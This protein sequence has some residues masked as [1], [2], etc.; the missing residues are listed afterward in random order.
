M[1]VQKTPIR[2]VHLFDEVRPLKEVLVWGEP[3][4]ETLLGQL[5]PQSRSLFHTY[6]EVPQAR[7]EFRH[8]QELLRGAGV[9]VVR[10]KDVYAELL[11]DY[12]IP[13]LPATLPGLEQR[14]LDKADRFYK[15]YFQEEAADLKADGLPLSPAQL[16]VQVRADIRQVLQEDAALYGEQAAIRLN[17]ALSLAREMPLPDIFYGRDQSNAIGERIVLSS[18][19]Y[20]IRKPEV[21]IYEQA[22]RF[23][24]YGDNLV[25]VERGIIEGGDSIVFGDTCY[26]GVGARTS[27]DAVTNLYEKIGPELAAKG[28]GLVAVVNQKHAAETFR[29]ESPA[30]ELMH[31]MHLDMFWNPLDEKSVVAFGE[32]IDRRRALVFALEDGRPVYRDS[33]TFREYLQAKGLDIL[34]INADEQQNLA[35]NIVNLG[36]HKIMVPLSRNK[37]VLAELERRGFSILQAEISTLVGGYGAV[38]C[39]TAAIRRE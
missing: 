20:D 33:G 11:K 32:E 10:I 26:I 14:L 18:M 38:H 19:R 37:R 21:A 39:L 25:S 3:G 7:Q 2:G 31:I 22:L 36:N 34:E 15:T 16:Y 1:S 5:L 4:C 12:A 13:D 27:L 17:H 30:G 35:A 9:Q 29:T 24:G 23:M 8:M 6:Y 28:L